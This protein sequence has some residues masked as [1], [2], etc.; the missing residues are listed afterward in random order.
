MHGHIVTNIYVVDWY[1]I[2]IQSYMLYYCEAL[3]IYY[4]VAQIYA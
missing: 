2:F 3:L 4:K 1:T